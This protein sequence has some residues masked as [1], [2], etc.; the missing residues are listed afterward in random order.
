MG[1]RI[2]LTLLMVP[3]LC[4]QC[5]A[6]C[7]VTQCAWF[8]QF[9]AS[10]ECLALEAFPFVLTALA[11]QLHVLDATVAANIAC[12][13]P[14]ELKN[15]WLR[16]RGM[17]AHTFPKQRFLRHFEPNTSGAL[18]TAPQYRVC[19]HTYMH[20]YRNLNPIYIYIYMYMYLGGAT[21]RSEVYICKLKRYFTSQ[22]RTTK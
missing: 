21:D 7:F 10:W 6:A 1:V 9:N 13:Q 22:D 2:R 14:P 8:A 11:L 5:S 20:A 16:G 17:S 19:I 3:G 4:S 12:S 18:R 15:T